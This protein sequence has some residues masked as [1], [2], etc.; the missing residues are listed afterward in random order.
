M[1]I[2]CSVSCQS[3]KEY[4]AEQDPSEDAENSCR[5]FLC[6]LHFGRPF[7]LILSP[8]RPVCRAGGSRKGSSQLRSG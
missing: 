8:I 7:N 6:I 4:S 3:G 2:G 5:S 1:D